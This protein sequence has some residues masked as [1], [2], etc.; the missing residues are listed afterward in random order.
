MKKIMSLVT[1]ILLTN[2]ALG[3]SGAG[4]G[5][6]FDT[7]VRLPN[8]N[9]SQ[10]LELKVG[11]ERDVVVTQQLL[12]AVV[13]LKISLKDKGYNSTEI[14]EVIEECAE[15]LKNEVCTK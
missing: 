6:V 10:K 2:S 8:F 3:A 9:L 13:E 15:G 1:L 12:N 5:G 4:S 7:P 11:L 14:L